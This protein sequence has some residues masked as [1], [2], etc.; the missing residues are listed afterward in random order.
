MSTTDQYGGGGGGGAAAAA[1]AA[2]EA[3]GRGGGAGRGG[4]G[5][6]ASCL[7]GQLVKDE[8]HFSHPASSGKLDVHALSLYIRLHKYKYLG[9][10]LINSHLIVMTL[11]RL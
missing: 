2:A 3:I 10:Y 8:D 5:G 1:A 7:C 11:T 4:E 6:G 9:L